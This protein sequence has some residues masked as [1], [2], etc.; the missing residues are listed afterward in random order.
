MVARSPKRTVR[1]PIGCSEAEISSDH[2][3]PIADP[4]QRRVHQRFPRVAR[5]SSI[6]GAKALAAFGAT[7]LAAPTAKGGKRT[8]PI[9]FA[10]TMRE[11]RDS[12]RVFQAYLR[13]PLSPRI[14]NGFF[15]NIKNISGSKRKPPSCF[16]CLSAS[17]M[18]PGT[19]HTTTSSPKSSTFT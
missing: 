12:D 19:I 15:L 9:G 11:S 13:Q 7:P 8:H 1:G 16:A 2:P 3:G 10:D 5:C 17:S 4:A 14:L 6:E 18:S